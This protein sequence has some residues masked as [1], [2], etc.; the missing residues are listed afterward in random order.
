MSLIYKNSCFLD[1]AVWLHDGDD[2]FEG[3]GGLVYVVDER[4]GALD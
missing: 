2:P 1:M 4:V 3:S